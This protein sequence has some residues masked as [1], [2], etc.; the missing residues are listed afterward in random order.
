M[1]WLMFYKCQVGNLADSA[2][3]ILYIIIISVSLW[4]YVNH[5][6]APARKSRM[7]VTITAPT[8]RPPGQLSCP[9][10]ACSPATAGSTQWD[11]DN[12]GCAQTTRGDPL[13]HPAPGLGQQAREEDAWAESHSLCLPFLPSG[14]RPASQP[15]DRS[16][17]VPTGQADL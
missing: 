15:P 8:T 9:C 17:S 6:N 4:F 11:W 5:R 7:G 10:G 14:I 1:L 12:V 2:F 16:P 13:S 3:H